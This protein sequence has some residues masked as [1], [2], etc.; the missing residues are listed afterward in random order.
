MILVD[1]FV[2][3]KNDKDLA[4]LCLV[5]G[6]QNQSCMED[7]LIF[8]LKRNSLILYVFNIGNFHEDLFG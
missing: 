4:L 7:T 6:A 2:F 5:L 3:E 1:F 8:I